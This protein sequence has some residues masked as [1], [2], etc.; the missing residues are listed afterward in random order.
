MSARNEIISLLNKYCYSVDTGD[1]DGF[2]KLYESAEWYVEGSPPNR[3]SKEIYD[4]VISNIIIYE[5]DTPKTKHITA[6]VEL[7]IDEANGTA[8][9][10]RYITVMQQTESFPLQA[11]FSGHY[12]D[13]FVYENGQWRYAKTVIRH[14]LVGDMSQHMKA[15]EGLSS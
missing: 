10:Q 7:I 2:I 15:T 12:F 5:D 13:E 6:N 3:G 14:P 9:C 1:L 11:I 8:N 4:N